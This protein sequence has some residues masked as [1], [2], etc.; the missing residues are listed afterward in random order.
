MKKINI[1]LVTFIV[2]IIT[3]MF[4]IVK[5]NYFGSKE[6]NV[7]NSQD[8][9]IN[10]MIAF[11]DSENNNSNVKINKFQL[12]KYTIHESEHLIVDIE[13]ENNGT[14]ESNNI[15]VNV[16]P[17]A[18]AM[19][20]FSANTGHTLSNSYEYAVDGISKTIYAGDIKCTRADAVCKAYEKFTV[21]PSNSAA[22]TPTLSQ[23]VN[24]SLGKIKGGSKVNL[25]VKL[26]FIGQV[27]QDTMYGVHQKVAATI[28]ELNDNNQVLDKNTK[29]FS[30]S[31]AK[32]LNRQEITLLNR[33]KEVVSDLHEIIN[34]NGQAYLRVKYTNL[35]C[36]NA[37]WNKTY[38]S[39]GVNRGGITKAFST[40]T[41]TDED[42]EYAGENS[43]RLRIRYPGNIHF[44]GLKVWDESKVKIDDNTATPSI[45]FGAQN[46]NETYDLLLYIPSAYKNRQLC[47][48]PEFIV[49]GA[50]DFAVDTT[51]ISGINEYCVGPSLQIT[52]VKA[53]KIG[54]TEDGKIN[55]TIKAT[56]RNRVPDSGKQTTAEGNGTAIGAD[57]KYQLPN[58]IEPAPTLPRGTTYNETTRTLTVDTGV[59]KYDSSG[60]VEFPVVM[61]DRTSLTIANEAMSVEGNAYAGTTV[62]LNSG[63]PGDWNQ[64]GVV[65]GR[66]LV[67][68]RSYT[69]KKSGYKLPSVSEVYDLNKNG[70]VDVNDVALLSLGLVDGTFD[71]YR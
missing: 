10:D 1:L 8:T 41:N 27:G 33:D 2:G 45:T 71:I 11:V 32:S 44:Q 21:F 15:V 54:Y 17:H 62:S 61:S 51:G 55:A 12:E 29:Y 69:V 23:S 9:N 19:T 58:G 14:S 20:I 25:K 35:T 36:D 28:S 3:C 50:T 39:P 66:D 6:I 24:Y 57:V 18:R 5:D 42:K 22:G 56:I 70:S 68:A 43:G 16:T 48:N 59:I 30:Y 64:N 31:L 34:S 40:G 67:Y 60:V 26:K 65:D 37:C 38:F 13:I 49:E 52:G 46:E 7:Q 53:E 63:I 4:V 47:F